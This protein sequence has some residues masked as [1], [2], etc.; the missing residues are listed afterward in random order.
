M[1]QAKKN[2][3]KILNAIKKIKD[4]PTVEADSEEITGLTSKIESAKS[5]IIMALDDDF[6][7]PVAIS[8]I[9]ILFRELNQAI[10]EKKIDLND[11]FKEIFF[12]FIEDIDSIFGLFPMLKKG[13]SSLIDDK[14]EKIKKLLE[15]IADIRSK[16]RKNKMYEISDEIREKLRELGFNIED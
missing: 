12:H 14:D 9:M 10:L 5:N 15:L 13:D 1:N 4:A 16:L 11:N 8:E 2:Y 7:T 3:N 6:N